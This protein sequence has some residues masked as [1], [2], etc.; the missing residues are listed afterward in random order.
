MSS[1]PARSTYLDGISEEA[2]WN[3]LR[4]LSSAPSAP[5]SSGLVKPEDTMSCVRPSSSLRNL[6][7]V[8]FTHIVVVKD[9]KGWS[10]VSRSMD[11]I[12]RELLFE[13]RLDTMKLQTWI[14]LAGDVLT[15]LTLNAP[16]SRATMRLLNDKCPALCSLT[17]H[18]VFVNRF[19][20]DA[21]PFLGPVLTSL[22]IKGYV[23]VAA[24]NVV[25]QQCPNLLRISI[26]VGSRSQAEYAKLL[27][28]Y[29][30]QL[31]FALIDGMP[32]MLCEEVTASCPNMRCE[33]KHSSEYNDGARPTIWKTC[34]RSHRLSRL[35]V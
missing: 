34:E 18:Y 22:T 21:L 17:L 5:F 9:G 30:D 27:C 10:D 23:G 20:F 13:A 8:C 33:Y 31:R 26:D 3:F 19:V 14:Q 25:Q 7:R 24:M 32:K 28:S 4:H 35:S 29:G 16:L 2:L 1:S 12:G 11:W 15:E 6:T